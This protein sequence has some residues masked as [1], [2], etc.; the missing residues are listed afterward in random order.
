MDIGRIAGIVYAAATAVVAAFQIALALGAPWGSVRHGRGLS[1][2]VPAGH[3]RRRAD[4]VGS[5][6][7]RAAGLQPAGRHR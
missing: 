7:P 2:P 3:A 4:A 6:G 1:R 5:R